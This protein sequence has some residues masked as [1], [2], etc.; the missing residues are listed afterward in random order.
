MTSQGTHGGRTI[1]PDT[2]LKICCCVCGCAGLTGP[3]LCHPCEMAHDRG[4]DK[5]GKPVRRG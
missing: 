1:R 2:Q 4:S 3:P 5:H